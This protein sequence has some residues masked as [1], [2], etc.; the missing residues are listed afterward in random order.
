[1][2]NMIDIDDFIT[3]LFVL[4]DD[5]CEEEPSPPKPG[6]DCKFSESEAMTLLIFSQWSRFLSERDFYRFAYKELRGAF[7]DLPSRPQLNRQWRSLHD[8]VCAFF[9]YL[10][11]ALDAPEALYEALDATAVVTRNAKRRGGGWLVGEADIG[12]SNRL[13]WFEGFKLLLATTPEGVITG[14]GL[15]PAS[16]KDQPM[17]ETFFYL[18]A[19]PDPRV[20]SIGE[21]ACGQYYPVD[22]G[23]EG[24]KNHER[25]RKAYRAYVICPPKSNS[26]NPWPKALRR[27]VASIRQM[28]E[29]VFDKLLY[30]FRLNRERPHLLQGARTRLAAKVALHNFCIWLNRQL[31]RPNL[32]FADLLGWS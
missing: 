27:W 30:T 17:A 26:Q 4:V 24:P 2:A 31:G 22:K 12:Y 5:F 18:R 21:T 25:W 23:F 14:F 20:A 9:T 11:D 15:S 32:A 19:N 3:T 6:P 28:V 8:K 29:T 7:P 1:M 13:G 10:A 16:A